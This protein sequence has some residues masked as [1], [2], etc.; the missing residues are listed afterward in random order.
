MLLLNEQTRNEKT[1]YL[2]HNK[3]IRSGNIF[4]RK[5]FEGSGNTYWVQVIPTGFR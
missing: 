4:N 1:I 2:N 3:K 5:E